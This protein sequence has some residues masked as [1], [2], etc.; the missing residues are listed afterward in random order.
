VVAVALVIRRAVGK[1]VAGA[2]VP[3]GGAASSAS[4]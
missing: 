4:Q 1:R 2:S 3:P